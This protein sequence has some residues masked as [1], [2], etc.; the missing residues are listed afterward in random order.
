MKIDANRALRPMALVCVAFTA[1][2]CATITRGVH[3]KWSVESEP[4]GASVTTTNGFSCQ[5]TPCTFTMERKA[6]F[7]VTVSKDGYKPYSGHIDHTVTGGGGTAL[8][9]N[10]IIGGIVGIG[11]DATTGA[12]DDLRPNPLKVHLEPTG[13]DKPSTAEGRTEI[14][15]ADKD[16]PAGK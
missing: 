8:A 15:T 13:S 14:K 7:E 4:P 3:Q 12:M 9:G 2:A 1:T 16:K 6:K 11:V 10:A 5:Q